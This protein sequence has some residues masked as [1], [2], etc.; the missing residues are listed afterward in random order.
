LRMERHSSN[1]GA[2]SGSIRAG[3]DIRFIGVP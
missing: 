1:A 3:P 2:A